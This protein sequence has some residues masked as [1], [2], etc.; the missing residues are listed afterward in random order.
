[1]IFLKLPICTCFIRHTAT[2]LEACQLQFGINVPEA[3][4]QPLGS[5]WLPYVSTSYLKRESMSRH[6]RVRNVSDYRYVWILPG[7]PSASIKASPPPPVLSSHSPRHPSF[8]LN[9]VRSAL[10]WLQRLQ[11]RASPQLE[12]HAPICHSYQ[13]QIY[14]PSTHSMSYISSKALW[15]FQY[16]D[17]EVWGRY[18]WDIHA[19]VTIYAFIFAISKTV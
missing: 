6:H 1:M 9:P 2:R 16:R 19:K 5:Q 3:V 15:R 7:N 13:P 4:E 17:D 8:C 14:P 12:S 18:L 10:G 11:R